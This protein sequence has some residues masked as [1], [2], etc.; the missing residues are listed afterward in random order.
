MLNRRFIQSVKIEWDK[1]EEYSYLRAIPALK[2]D[3][4]LQFD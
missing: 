2:F 4:N 1:I 3:G